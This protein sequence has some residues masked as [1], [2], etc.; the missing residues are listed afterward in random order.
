MAAEWGRFVEGHQNPSAHVLYNRRLFFSVRLFDETMSYLA[1]LIW[2]LD[3]QLSGTLS[4]KSRRTG[5]IGFPLRVFVSIGKRV[6]DDE[7]VLGSP[8]LRTVLIPA[9]RRPFLGCCLEDAASG[10]VDPFFRPLNHFIE[11]WA[12]PADS[13]DQS[14]CVAADHK[15]SGDALATLPL[16]IPPPFTIRQ[17]GGN[18]PRARVLRSTRSQCVCLRQ[19]F[20]SC[21]HP[22]PCGL[23]SA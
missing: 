1:L 17:E 16:G 19:K 7:L 5:F 8:D 18:L 22:H 2:G 6:V 15:C 21:N 3:V 9:T 14:P 23:S 4:E 10:S 11:W 12:F 13:F 20:R